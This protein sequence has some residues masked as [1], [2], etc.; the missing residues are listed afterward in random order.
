MESP[1]FLSKDSNL[2]RALSI[3][4]YGNEVYVAGY[5]IAGITPIAEY[6]K[7]GNQVILTDGSNN[8]QARSIF[9][10][11]NDVY[12]AGEESGVSII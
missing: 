8:A 7:N 6:W 1:S 11:M 12:V 3:F 9:V 2:K 5:L 10:A 4:V